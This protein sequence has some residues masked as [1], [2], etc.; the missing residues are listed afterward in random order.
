MSTI[1][2]TI[3]YYENAATDYYSSTVDVD[4]KPQ[5][6]MF[7]KYLYEGARI[8]DCG[9]GSGRDSKH[10]LDSGYSVTAVDGS[11]SMCKMASDLTG[12]E[13]FNIVFQDID[14]DNEFDGVWACASLLHV[15]SD[16]IA[17][18]LKR[19]NKAL[20]SNGILYV[21]FK[22]GEYEGE[23][24]GRFYLDLTEDT[25]RKIL[26]E[27]GGFDIKEIFVSDDVRPEKE[28]VQWLNA[29]L[30]KSEN[31]E[32]ETKDEL[33]ETDS[34]EKL[35]G[36]IVLDAEGHKTL[37]IREGMSDIDF[38]GILAKAVQWAD[39]G[40]VI[41]AIEKKA[42]YVVQ[43]P[44]KYQKQF[45]AGELFI[46]KNTKTGIEWPTLMRKADNG[47]YQFVDNLPIEQ[48]KFI[49][50]NPFHDICQ[51][52]HNMYIQQQIAEISEAINDLHDIV[53]LIAQ[54]QQDDRVAL[55]E[56]GRDEIMLALT[57]NDE[58]SR[59]IHISNGRSNLILG[60]AR[61]GKALE[62]R[63]SSFEAIPENGLIRF[64]KSVLKSNYLDK[65]DDE[66]EEIEQCF[67]LYHKATNMLAMSWGLTGELD[68]LQST[69]DDS[70]AFIKGLNLEKV[71]T[72]E[73]S[74]KGSDLSDLFYKTALGDLKREKQICLDAAKN[75]EYISIEVSGD[76]LLEVIENG[77]VK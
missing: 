66:Y 16:E 39:I 63:V 2:R 38:N 52:Y 55:I 75:Y 30:I 50:G 68:A 14:F 3:D 17:L 46:N 48:Q 73:Y 28:N 7:E 45:E 21:S 57:V 36:E 23:R 8:L 77:K 1:S 31:L 42:E 34:I 67:E 65:K 11:A 41:S 35:Q 29:I 59:R 60:K 40:K 24:N 25:L 6:S 37:T 69:Y 44:A 47:R 32:I 49:Q 70:H 64:G 33:I 62:R 22:Y 61:L 74:H 20:A 71:K 10:F 51:N 5:Y 58:E 43:I 26:D 72:I 56:A 18:V 13:V 4:M 54:G 53:E 9:C 27:V 76:K 15:P 12:L 19:V